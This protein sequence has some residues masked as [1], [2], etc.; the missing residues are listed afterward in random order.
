MPEMQVCI[1]CRI[2]SGELSSFKVYEDSQVVAILDIRPINRGHTLIMTKQHYEN[3]HDIPEKLLAHVH[4]I[5]KRIAGA[6]KRVFSPTGISIAQNSGAAAGQ[7][8]FHFHAHVIPKDRE[9]HQRY[10]AGEEDLQMV[11]QKLKRSLEG[12]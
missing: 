2:V 7:V 1:F 9:Q 3:I 6:Q 8:V 12:D 10:E 4:K 5:A 11:A